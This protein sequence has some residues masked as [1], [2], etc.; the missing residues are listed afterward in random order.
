[1]FLYSTLIIE[2]KK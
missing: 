2:M 1:M